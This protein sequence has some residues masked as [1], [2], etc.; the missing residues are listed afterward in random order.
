[1]NINARKRTAEL[2]DVSQ[3]TDEL[4]L[5]EG[6]EDYYVTPKAEVYH[7]YTNTGYFKIKTCINQKAGGYVYV[8]LQINGKPKSFRLHRLVA[9]AFI[10]N[11]DNLP[12]VDH[13]DNDK[14]HNSVDN[15]QW[16]TA[17]QNAQ[18]RNDDGLLINA[19]GFENPQSTAVVCFTP[20]KQVYKIYGSM[21]LAHAD[22]GV[23]KSTVSRQIN[24]TS[25]SIR[26]G[27]YFRSLAEYQEKGFVL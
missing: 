20:D 22:L 27:Y 12:Q 18:K 17:S 21:S 11:P 15:L 4:R 5:I 1:M 9:L 26:C 25:Q 19:K 16:V 14:T 7:K 23:S 6:T 13:I 24:H 8:T 10:P 3:I 2:I